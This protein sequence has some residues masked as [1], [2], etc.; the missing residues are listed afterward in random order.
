M[1]KNNIDLN[2]KKVFAARFSIISN[3]TLVGLKFFIG[4]I[5]SSVS[6]IAEAIHSGIDLVAAIIANYSVRKSVQ[7]P[8]DSHKFGHGK[9]ENI[10]ALIEGMLILF[11]AYLILHEAY[12]K[13]VRPV[14]LNVLGVGI[15]IMLIS[16]VSNYYISKYLFKVSKETDSAALEADAWHL[17]TDVYTS[18]GVF[19]GLFLINF[20]P[21]KGIGILD[22]IVAI[23]TALLI[24]KAG[25]NISKD[26]ILNLADIKLPQEQENLIKTAIEEN[27]EKFVTFHNLRTRRAG[28][29]KYIDLHLVVSKDLHVDKAHK[30][31]HHL[32]ADIR[33][34]LKNTDVMIHLEPCDS[35]C[36]ICKLECSKHQ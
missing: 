18:L 6:I 19:I 22:P 30:L 4:I 14:L 36:E 34:K 3:A 17:R 33:N 23:L 16:T 25:Y 27:S 11:A 21:I 15:G 5:T 28:P 2:K 29:Y 35:K 32:T 20:V 31:T 10:S 7:P 26:A 9:V 24:I 1:G 12:E 13:I 8:D